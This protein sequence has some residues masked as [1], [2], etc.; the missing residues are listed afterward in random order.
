MK[1][2]G[3]TTTIADSTATLG[4]V[5]EITPP[6][7]AIDELETTVHDATYWRTFCAGL[8]NG[9]TLGV[10]IFYDGADAS[11]N[12]LYSRAIG[13]PSQ[14]S[15]TYTI[16]FPDGKTMVFTGII[17]GVPIE[18]PI[19]DNILLSFN[20]KVSGAITGTLGS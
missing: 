9:G 3:K 10:T 8:K 1:Y 17:T 15:D 5:K 14:N 13:D 19:D 16:T 12:R 2:L 11:M 4:E 7:I 18:T 20:I 6:E